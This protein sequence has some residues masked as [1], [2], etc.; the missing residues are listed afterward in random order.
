MKKKPASRWTVIGILAFSFVILLALFILPHQ[1]QSTPVEPVPPSIAAPFL[2]KDIDATGVGSEPGPKTVVNGIAYFA[3]YD[4]IHGAEL[5][6][7]DGTP[8][9]TWLVK[10]IFTGTSSSSPTSL[11]GADDKLFFVADDGI[12]GQELWV[13]DGTPGGTFFVKD[14]W[15]YATSSGIDYL[16]S[17][18]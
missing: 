3:A 2:L 5:W 18:E 6:R 15:P 14:I 4:G 12:H 9:G 17:F 7:S 1:A 13:S 16:L 10:D 11:V 8:A